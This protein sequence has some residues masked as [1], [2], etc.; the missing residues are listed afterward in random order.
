MRQEFCC[1]FSFAI[2]HSKSA[3]RNSAMVFQ[4][5]FTT[6]C[7]VFIPSGGRG[8]PWAA[9]HHSSL[10]VNLC[11]SQSSF[12]ES[13]FKLLQLF[14]L[15]FSRTENR[16]SQSHIVSTF[17]SSQKSMNTWQALNKNIYYV[18][19][20]LHLTIPVSRLMQK[21][22]HK[23]HLAVQ[24]STTMGQPTRQWL[25]FLL[26]SPLVDANKQLQNLQTR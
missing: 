12:L 2:L 21:G 3:G 24:A 1:I 11:F 26:G 15:P 17:Q 4:D 23:R 14:P 10:L 22:L 13:Y 6:S 18:A 20:R 19:L 7:D 25:Q 5:Q 9:I 16:I 8:S